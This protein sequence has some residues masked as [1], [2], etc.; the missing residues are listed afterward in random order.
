MVYDSMAVG[1][2]SVIL[3][4]PDYH[5]D[6]FGIL[7]NYELRITNYEL[8]EAGETEETGKVGVVESINSIEKIENPQTQKNR[9]KQ[10]NLVIRN[11]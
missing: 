1:S 4:L 8:K 7:Y 10:K 3:F 2:Q 5:C 11:S 9:K 6:Q